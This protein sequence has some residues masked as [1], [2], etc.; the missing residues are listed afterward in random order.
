MLMTQTK[1]P[2][3][4][5]EAL[6]PKPILPVP[7]VWSQPFWEHAKK[8]QLALQQCSDC[9][10]HRYPPSPACSKCLSSSCRWMVTSGRGLVMSWVVFHQSYYPGSTLSVPYNVA[11][12]AL[13][14][15]PLLISNIVDID[16]SNLLI[17]LPVEVVFRV[18]NE[19]F[20]LPQFRPRVLERSNV[21]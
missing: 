1:P 2:T 3:K 18:L 8:E 15:G 7:D 20:T 16:D 21:V 9:G 19:H 11:L 12:V 13:E 14:E 10:T 4:H 5:I 17:G 6:S